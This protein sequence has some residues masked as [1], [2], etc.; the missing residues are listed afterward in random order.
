MR[1]G[2]IALELEE[3][4]RDLTL[5]N[6]LRADVKRWRNAGWEGATNVAKDLLRRRVAAVNH[7]GRLGVWK[8]AVCRD[9]QRLPRLL[10]GMK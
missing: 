9:P 8:F 7:W 4:R 1:S 5:V 2:Q 10:A 3:D 6:R